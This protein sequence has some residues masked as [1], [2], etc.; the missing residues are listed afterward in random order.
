MNIFMN[1]R[2]EE[3]SLFEIVLNG[4]KFMSS[5]L[6]SSY[7][8]I[9]ALILFCFYV[10]AKIKKADPNKK[11]EGILNIMEMFVTTIDSLVESTMGSDKMKFAPYIGTL[12]LYLA[13]SNL[14]GLIALT[15]PTSDYNITLSLAL[16]TFAM[17]QFYGLTSK[18]LGGYVKGF[19]EPIPLLFPINVV[20]ELANPVSLSFRLFGNVL[21]GAII[22]S[23]LYQ[24]LA[25]IHSLV[26]PIVAPIIAVPFHGYF[27]IFSGL[28]QTFIFMMLTMVFVSMNMEE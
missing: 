23:L 15:P 14:S 4:E 28:V 5:S 2:K 18:G 6:V 7:I 11:P 9:I 21:S 13:L 22:M 24:A 26:G 19:F 10:N 12:A 8:I 3:T 16:I 20:G 25:G 1:Q 17:T 27:D